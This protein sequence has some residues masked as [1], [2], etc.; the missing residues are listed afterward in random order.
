MSRRLIPSAAFRILVG[1][2]AWPACAALDSGV[3]QT[4]S[5]STVE[6]LGDL[7]PNGSRVV[8]ISAT[9]TFDLSAA[10]PSVTAVIADA[11]VEGGDPFALTVRSSSG[12]QL[13]DGTCTF[14]G[15]YLRDIHPSGTQYLFDWRFSASTNGH[16]LWNGIIGWAGGHLWQVTISN[17]TLVP[18][19]RL[20]V[21]QAG[22]EVTVSWPVSATGYKL[23]QAADL[24]ATDWSSVTNAV[25]T[26]GDRFSVRVEAHGAQRFFRL[27]R[28]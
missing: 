4:L 15:D 7:V 25:A 24:P 1:L 26:T 27:R 19:P 20:E 14:T 21:T 11:V 10:S 2:L 18:V 22:P 12:A 23:E 5:D 17:L 8:P 16:V 3:Y 28:F 9:L 6:E 13:V